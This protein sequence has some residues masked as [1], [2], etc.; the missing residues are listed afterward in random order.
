MLK[1]KKSLSK[2]QIPLLILLKV[3]KRNYHLPTNPN[4]KRTPFVRIVLGFFFA[5]L[6]S[7]CAVLSRYVAIVTL[8]GCSAVIVFNHARTAVYAAKAA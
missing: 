3:F 2:T 6:V 5:V 8:F 7:H 1:R 4:L